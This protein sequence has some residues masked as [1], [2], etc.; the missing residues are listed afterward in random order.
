MDGKG[1][2]RDHLFVERLWRN[3][4]HGEVTC[5]RTPAFPRHLAGIG[6]YIGFCNSRP[7]RSSLEGETRSGLLQPAGA[8]SGSGITEAQSS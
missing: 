5:A 8:I 4:K 1:A 7:L 2:W 6:R 3:I